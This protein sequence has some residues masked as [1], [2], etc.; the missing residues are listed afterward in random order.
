[1]TPDRKS[2][3]IESIETIC[4]AT[5]KLVASGVDKSEALSLAQFMW[6]QFDDTPTYL[7][8][9]V[10]GVLTK[11]QMEAALRMRYV[12]KTLSHTHAM[13]L[14]QAAIPVTQEHL[15]KDESATTKNITDFLATNEAKVRSEEPIVKTEERKV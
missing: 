4:E 8:K 12:D 15:D 2:R 9:T 13:L 11:V 1:M 7:D 6:G 5:T 14:A 10:G 3:F